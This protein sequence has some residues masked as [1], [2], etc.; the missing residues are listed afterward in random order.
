M[1]NG[2]YEAELTPGP[3]FG[4]PGIDTEPIFD[5]LNRHSSPRGGSKKSLVAD[6]GNPRSWYGAN[7]TTAVPCSSDDEVVNAVVEHIAEHDY[8]FA[9]MTEL[10]N[11]QRCKLRTAVVH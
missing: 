2:S 11:I 5:R 9:R 4:D 3:E 7:A 6:Y 10:S 8:I 1:G